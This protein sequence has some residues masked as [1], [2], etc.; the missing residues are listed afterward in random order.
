[1]LAPVTLSECRRF[2]AEHHRHNIA[3]QGWLWG[4]SVRDDDGDLLGVATAGRPVARALDDGWTVEVTRTCT[5]GEPNANSML[6]GACIRAAKAL[7]YRRVFTYKLCS[8]SGASLR[9]V[10]FVLDAVLPERAAWVRN[11][12]GRYQEDLFGEPRRPSEA[13][14]R[15]KWERGDRTQEVGQ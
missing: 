6:Y 14:E 15:W 4:V 9:A 1:M 13:K 7:G 2:V 11:D 3:P 8:E 5:T 12:G 10:G